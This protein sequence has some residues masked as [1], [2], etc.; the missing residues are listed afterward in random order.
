M[1]PRTRSP[2]RI[3]FLSNLLCAAIENGGYGF[4]RTV[5]WH[6]PPSNPAAWQAV[7]AD[8][9]DG[10]KQY[11]ITL[12]TMAKGLGV[13]RRAIVATSDDGTFYHNAETFERLYVPSDARREL[14]LADRTDGDDGDYDVVGALA[15]LEC[16]LFGRVVYC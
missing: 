15:V 14:L 5:T 1:A 6:C 8:P 10:G 11:R 16:A 3:E 9:D 7:I 13:I 4:F 12:D 2:E